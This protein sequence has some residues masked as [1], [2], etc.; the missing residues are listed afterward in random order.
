MSYK[1]TKINEAP[2]DI[3]NLAENLANHSLNFIKTSVESKAKFALFHAFTNVHIP[4]MVNQKFQGLSKDHGDYGDSIIEMDHQVGRILDLLDQLG[5]SEDTMVYFLSDHGA[6]I[7]L[8]RLG[9]SNRPFR[10]GK[11]MGAFE[12]GI[13][14]PGIIRW[15]SVVEPQTEIC[16]PTSTMD[17]LPTLAE[18]L[19]SKVD[20]KPVNPKIK[21][22]LIFGFF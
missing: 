3:N 21:Y 6:H 1:D 7:D 11:A 18:L 8:G 22:K 5:V 2:L 10:G 12:G 17:F 14:V 16:V 13:R 19:A 15:P 4:L 9:G 20:R